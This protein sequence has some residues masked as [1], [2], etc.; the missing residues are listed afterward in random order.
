MTNDADIESQ[1]ANCRDYWLGWGSSERVDGELAYYRSG[2]ADGQ[3]NGVL[4]LRRSDRLEKSLGY[5][6]ERLAGVPWMWWVG[7]D[8]APDVA[9]KLAASGAVRLGAMPVMTIRTDKATPAEGPSDLEIEAVKGVDALREWVQAYAPSFGVAPE[10]H[11]DLL[12][13]EIERHN[14]D[15]VVRFIGR[16]NGKAVGTSLMFD[17]HGVAGVYV[18]TTSEDHRRKGI[19]TAL[20]AAALEAGRERGLSVGTLQSSPSGF[21]VYQRMGF[22]TVAEYELFQIPSS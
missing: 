14:G 3:L 13:N 2:I 15:R 9:A 8:S 18:V 4:S 19:G 22:E 7:P 1:L 16:R 11:D 6:A 21:P 17:A 20:T 12:R 10:A 5:A